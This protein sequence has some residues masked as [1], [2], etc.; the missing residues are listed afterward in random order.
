MSKPLSPEKGLP[1]PYYSD[2][3]VTLYHGDCRPALAAMAD[4]SVDL[5]ITD[6]PFDARTHAMARSNST[7]NSLSGRGSRT[8]SGG[9]TVRFDAWDHSA[10][11]AL[12]ASIGRITRRWVVSNASTDTAFRFEVESPPPGLRVARVGAW[13]KT[14]PMPMIAADRP[15]MGWE[16]LL[17]MHRDDLKLDWYGG[18]RA[19][20]FYLPT[21]QG[22]GH[23]TA[24][25]LSMVATW[26]RLFSQPG[27]LILDPFGGTGTTARAC[28]DEG[29][30]CIVWEESERWCEYTARRL[31]QDTLFG[32]GVA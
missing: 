1:E 10:Q 18:G 22:T 14:N 5:V 9:S 3:S 31:S 19:A 12:F 23:P 27:D 29:R 4:R 16:P 30:R 26:V 7:Q 17:Y 13:I 15:A 2:E 21:E 8:L 6:P 24:K 25:P 28:K 11:T 32:G 20:N